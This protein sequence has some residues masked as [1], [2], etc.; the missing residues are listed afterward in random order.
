MA[1]SKKDRDAE[2]Q[3][4]AMSALGDLE[5]LAKMLDEQE[6]IGLGEIGA[7]TLDRARDDLA[8]AKVLIEA[9]RAS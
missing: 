4:L 9:G 7:R 2:I 3:R 5:A 1:M 6:G 8:R